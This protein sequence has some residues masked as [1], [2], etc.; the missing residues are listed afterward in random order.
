[1]DNK[2]NPKMKEISIEFILKLGEYTRYETE[3]IINHPFF[4]IQK[5]VCFIRYHFHTIETLVSNLNTEERK[6]LYKMFYLE[7]TNEEISQNADIYLTKTFGNLS[8][9]EISQLISSIVNLS[10]AFK[11]RTLQ[12]CVLVE[13]EI[14][15][16]Y[17]LSI[18]Q[19]ESAPDYKK[20]LYK[21]L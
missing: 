10:Y 11:N 8:R 4:H 3:F 2:E 14:I 6:E 12:D 5:A 16:K 1:M 19:L 21:L 15:S 13:D 18:L 9:K 20:H 7:I 17:L